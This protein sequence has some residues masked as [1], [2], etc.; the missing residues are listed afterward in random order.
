MKKSNIQKIPEFKKI[1]NLTKNLTIK[2][3]SKL[4]F[5][6]LPTNIRYKSKYDNTYYDLIKNIVSELSIPFIDIHEEVFEKQKNPLKLF[7]FSKSGHYNVE[8]YKKV[9]ETIY[10]LTKD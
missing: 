4:Y 9:A 2:N 3:N 1:L 6:Y 7:P 10:K 8:G 5:V